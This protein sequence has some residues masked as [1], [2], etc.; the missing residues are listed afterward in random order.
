MK[1]YFKKNCFFIIAF[2]VCIL[3]SERLYADNAASVSNSIT[4]I[5]R[6]STASETFPEDLLYPKYFKSHDLLLWENIKRDLL[7]KLRFLLGRRFAQP[8]TFCHKFQRRITRAVDRAINEGKVDITKI[9]NKLLFEENEDINKI[10]SPLPKLLN[11]SCVYHSFGDIRNIEHSLYEY[12]GMDF[13]SDFYI[14]HKKE[15]EASKPF[16]TSEDIAELIIFLPSVILLIIVLL[17]LPDKKKF[18]LWLFRGFK[19]AEL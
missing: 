5:N 13:E 14:E 6:S 9:D 17:F 15:L 12:H 18:F 1:Q 16:I 11:S 2:F 19:K 7:F 4:D 8:Y 10:I 3:F